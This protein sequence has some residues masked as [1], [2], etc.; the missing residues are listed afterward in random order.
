MLGIAASSLFSD[1]YTGLAA[2]NRSRFGVSNVASSASSLSTRLAPWKAGA[3][4]EQAQ[5]SMQSNDRDA[6]FA[7]IEKAIYWMPAD[8]EKWAFMM[9][10]LLY[11]GRFDDQ[12][13]RVVQNIY[14]LAPNAP[15]LQKL[16]AF[17][18][19]YWWLQ[20]NTDLRKL[21]LRGMQDAL[22]Y[23]KDEFLIAVVSKRKENKLCQY[24]GPSLGLDKWCQWARYVRHECSAGRL[25]ADQRNGCQRL[26]FTVAASP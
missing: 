26:G 18:G 23:Q 4:S 9:Q 10:V 22:A 3:W 12:L 15:N 7:S 1:L 14:G 6:A 8:A 2:Q 17:D 19:L 25:T 11:G 20:S 24:A 5:N 21:W 13:E 16:I